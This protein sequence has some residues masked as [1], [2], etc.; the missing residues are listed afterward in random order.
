MSKPNDEKPAP[1]LTGGAALAEFKRELEA[2]RGRLNEE[3][4]SYPAP[5]PA[6]DAQFNYLLGQRTKI[7]GEL[8]R[9]NDLIGRRRTPGAGDQDLAECVARIRTIDKDLAG[10]LDEALAGMDDPM[11]GRKPE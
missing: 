1:A 5:I 2:A 9:I 8:K 4:G 3:I 11:A 6:C 10:R 7:A